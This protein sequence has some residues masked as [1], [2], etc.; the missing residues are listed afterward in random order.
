M[1]IVSQTATN[2][3]KKFFAASV[4]TQG[5]CTMKSD[6]TEVCASGDQLAA[7]LAGAAAGADPEETVEA[8]ASGAAQ[9]STAPT[10]NAAS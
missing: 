10:D 3:I 5:L 4:H 9:S 6:G 1:F 7:I 2:G 8:P